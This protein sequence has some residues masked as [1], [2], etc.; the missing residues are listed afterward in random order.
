MRYGPIADNPIEQKIMESP[1]APRGSFDTL[2]PVVQARAIMSGVSLGIFESLRN[3]GRTAAETASALNLD[4]STVELILRMLAGAGYVTRNA[5]RYALTDLS[6]STLLEESPARVRDFVAMNHLWWDWL[7]RMDDVTRTGRG[8]DIHENLGDASDWAIYQAAMLE[9]A[10]VNAPMVAPLVPVKPGAR[11]L[12]D[13]AGSHGLYG[14]LICRANPPM[15]SEVF[16]LPQAVEQSRRLAQAEGFDDVVTHR[17]GNALTEDLGRDYDVVFLG[18]ILH[19][20]TPRQSMEL[21]G[22]IRECLNLRG[23]VA[24]WEVRQ[25]EADEPPDVVG[26]GFALFFRVTSTA[27]CYATTE[28]R[29]WL[30]GAGF[31]DIHVHIPPSAPFQVLITGRVA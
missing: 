13:I 5:G 29:T 19:H 6:R 8:F 12:L 17:T 7:G 1:R 25:P 10:R 2:L 26:D 9:M 31:T 11:R 15:R 14:A 30:A 28:Y 4:T 21:L 16:D 22:R 23:T 20:F 18:N 27:R 3:G 24:I